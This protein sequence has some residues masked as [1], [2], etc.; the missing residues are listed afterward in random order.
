MIYPP[1]LGESA[2]LD[3]VL[4]GASLAR[5]GDGEFVLAEG[6]SIR[7][8]RADL[9]LC[10]RLREI[11]HG[12]TGGC[13]VG[14]PNLCATLPPKKATF[15][16]KYQRCTALLDP[17]MAYVSAFVTRPDNAPWIDAPNYW[18][19]VEALWQGRDVTLVRGEDPKGT[20]GVSFLASDLTSARSV[21]EIIGP[22]VNGWRSAASLLEQI[23]TPDRVLLCFG[24][25]ATVLAVD[26]HRR[27]VQAIDLGHLG[28]FRRRHLAGQSMER[29]RSAA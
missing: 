27:G 15:W 2:T 13:L 4:A 9:D 18:A 23:G 10:V 28:M 3:R 26:L 25:T 19:R 12:E 16:K 8:Q 24:P 21:R 11:L 22:A 29:D 7:T 1:V 17:T 6:K 5:F 20:G 14:I